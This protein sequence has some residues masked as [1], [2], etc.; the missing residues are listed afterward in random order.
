MTDEETS[1]PKHSLGRNSHA[2]NKSQG[3]GAN[4]QRALI[5]A[6]FGSVHGNNA[7]TIVNSDD[8][9]PN[10]SRTDN[11]PPNEM[12]EIKIMNT[13]NDVSSFVNASREDSFNPKC[14]LL[15]YSIKSK[16]LLFY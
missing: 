8:T 6:G 1:S 12:M 4:R 10:A 13:D 16:F 7:I 2:S 5:N 11:L 15:K 3:N 14:K 9:R